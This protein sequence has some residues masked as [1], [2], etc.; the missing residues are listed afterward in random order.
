[1]TSQRA[2]IYDRGGRDVYIYNHSDIIS[3]VVTENDIYCA[4]IGR[5][6]TI[7]VATKSTGYASEVQVMD[8]NGKVKYIW[9]SSD[10][11]VNNVAVSNNGRRIVV[12]TVSVSG[13]AYKSKVYVFKYS[14]ADPLY[15]LEYDNTIIYSIDCI[16]SSRFT[17]VT[18]ES[19]D[20]IKW[21]NGER[22]QNTNP[23]TLNIFRHKQNSWGIAVIGN[24]SSS[25]IIAYNKSGEKISSFDFDGAV[26]D[27]T[28]C[29]DN[30]YIISDGYMYCFDLDGNLLADKLNVSGYSRIFAQ[31]A[32]TAICAGNFG[33]DKFNID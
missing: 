20:F 5:N 22:K 2:A 6:G 9:Y 31:N 24:K 27:V 23:Y 3:E 17:V 4:D 7:A 14:S 30:I 28:M 13:G 1:M 8:K 32:S 25:S 10:E 21:K 19:V 15:V 16:S 11:T 18:D 33:L 29:K 26:S 12:S